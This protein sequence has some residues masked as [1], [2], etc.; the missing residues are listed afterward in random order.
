MIRIILFILPLFFVAET[1]LLHDI[2]DNCVIV[3]LVSK[4]YLLT[5]F[6]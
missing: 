5:L 4:Y 3:K 1:N 2:S 6:Q